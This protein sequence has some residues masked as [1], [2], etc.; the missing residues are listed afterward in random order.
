L[1]THAPMQPKAP[2]TSVAMPSFLLVAQ[3]VCRRLLYT[4]AAGPS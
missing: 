1:H 4:N 2:V 3:A